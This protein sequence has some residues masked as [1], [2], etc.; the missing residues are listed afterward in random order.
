[1][2]D[3]PLLDPQVAAVRRFNRLYTRTMGVLDEGHLHSP[4]SLTEVRVLYE[5]ANRPDPVA[6]EIGRE[7]AL[8]AGY[9][10]RMVRGFE[11]QGLV[12]RV[13]SPADAR[14]HLLRLTGRG[15]ETFAELDARANADVASLL[16][17]LGDADRA[18]LIGALQ[19]VE[20]L[21]GSRAGDEPPYILRPPRS[22]DYGWVV[23]RHGVLYGREYGW[24]VRFEALVAE[25][26]AGFIRNYDPQWER[27]WIAERG[28]QNVGCVFMMRKSEMVAQL[29]L[30]LVDPSAR[31]LGLGKR[32]VRECTA[33]AREKG[34][35]SI[36]L[37]TNS[38]L[39][40]ARHIYQAEGYQLVSEETH[41]HFGIDL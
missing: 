21:L 40:T 9:L 39:D 4:F 2:P 37:W 8:D 30:L 23:E 32:L 22:G 26:V 27:C 12:E 33:F 6:S 10:S 16:R 11:G 18:R 3:D 31:G 41:N 1:M 34:Y 28:G 5:L 7:L 15:H 25:V 13:P 38:V 24:D 17:T 35:R 20:A 29:R 36:V 19:T 14:Q